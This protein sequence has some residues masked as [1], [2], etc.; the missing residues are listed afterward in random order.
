MEEA[1]WAKWERDVSSLLTE[2]APGIE[3]G[4]RRQ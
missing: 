1:L 2:L 4:S 3:R